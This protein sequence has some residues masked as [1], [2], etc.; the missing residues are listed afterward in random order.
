MK[1]LTLVGLLLINI[2][3]AKAVNWIDVGLSSKKDNEKN[4]H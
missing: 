3:I 4:L 1:W 2:Q